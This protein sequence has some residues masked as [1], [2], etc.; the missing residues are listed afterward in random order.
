MLSDIIHL[1]GGNSSE[2]QSISTLHPTELDKNDINCL[3]LAM[4]KGFQKIHYTIKISNKLEE[5]KIIFK[6][7][8][9]NDLI[10]KKIGSI[11]YKQFF[12]YLIIYLIGIFSIIGFS[13]YSIVNSELISSNETK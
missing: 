13:N 11:K 2:M 9:K 3:K 5:L 6:K 10:N 1:R 7:S 8:K 4:D 12:I